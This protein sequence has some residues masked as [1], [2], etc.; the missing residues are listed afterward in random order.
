M[1]LQGLRRT[2]GQAFISSHFAIWTAGL[3]SLLVRLQIGGKQ[4]A[5]VP[6]RFEL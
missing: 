6:E 4:S 3:A 2:A 5:G 1:G